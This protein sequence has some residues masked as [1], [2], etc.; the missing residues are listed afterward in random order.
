MKLA[1]AVLALGATAPAATVQLTNPGVVSPPSCP[2]NPCTVVSRTT[3]I[4]VADGTVSGP[5]VVKQ[6]GRITSWSVTLATPVTEQIHYFDTH[7]GGPAEAEIGVLRPV[8]GLN[9]ELVSES[10]VVHFQPWFGK[11]A[12]IN[13]HR[14]LRVKPGEV[15]ALIVP[16][17]LPALALN[18]PSTTAWRAS[19]TSAAC[20]DV[21]D[22]TVQNLVGSRTAYGCLYTTAMVTYAA[23]EVT[24]RGRSR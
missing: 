7:E 19:R 21:A 5:F 22:Q 13:L 1:L 15:I 18:Y 3:A 6:R 12:K 14:S 8:G 20:N 9:Y 23:T 24:P 2:A 10:G 17:W 11:T 16:T 4:Q